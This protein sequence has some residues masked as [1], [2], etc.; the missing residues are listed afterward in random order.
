M[1]SRCWR[2]SLFDVSVWIL[3]FQSTKWTF[4]PSKNIK[5]TKV[6]APLRDDRWRLAFIALYIKLC[7]RGA[8]ASVFLMFWLGFLTFTP[9]N[10]QS[11][12][13]EIV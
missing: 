5:K 13:C 11:E 3:N 2:L 10:G 4:F 8:G 9:Q 7:C 6:K 12:W 1:L